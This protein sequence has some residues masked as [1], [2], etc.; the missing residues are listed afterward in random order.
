MLKNKKLMGNFFALAIL[1][2]ANYVFPFLTVPYLS[3]ILSVEHY[4]LILFSLSFTTYFSILCDYG[5]NLSATKE[6]AINSANP[7]A[8]N[9]LVSSV[10]LIKFI[11]L[12]VSIAINLIV[13]FSFVKFRD[14]WFIYVINLISLVNNV[15]FPV[16]F[17]QG[18]ERMRYITIIQ[19]SVRTISLILIFVLIKHDGQYYLWTLINAITS[20]VSVL[21]AQYVLIKSFGIK[22]VRVNLQEIKTQLI[23]GWHIFI[24]TV[25]I[26]LYTVSNSFLLGILTN[27]AMVAYYASAEKIM[28]AV[29]ALLGP[30]SQGIFPHLSKAI[31]ENKTEGIKLLQKA[32]IRIGA[33]GLLISITLFA[34]A[35]WIVKILFGAK[36][37]VATTE[38][39]RILAILPFI[40]CLSNIFGIQTMLPFGLTKPF[41]RILIV[42]SICNLIFIICLVPH[43]TYIGSAISVVMTE[44]LVTAM[45][46]LYLWRNGIYVWLGRLE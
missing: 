40:I 15:F 37:V 9:R 43:F 7:H 44:V 23:A 6:A 8:L 28:N 5:F 18:M 26:S 4:G 35:P 42:S 33:L 25:A 3:R 36:Y 1:Q 2:I 27:A 20:V 31:H 16:W 39:L 21:L 45:M 24:S 10:T 34:A 17:F 30:L 19:V 11:L 14:F 22:Y 41:S 13:V 32:L 38:V 29:Q 12:L 46:G